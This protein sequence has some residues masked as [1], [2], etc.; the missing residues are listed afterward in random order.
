M[1][2]KIYLQ[3]EQK[4]YITAGIQSITTILNTVLCVILINFGTSI[5]IVKLVSSFVFVLRPV[6]QNL[7]VRK[8]YNINLKNEKE[9]YELK[10][11]WD[12]LA[13][14]IAAVIH[15]NTD[16]TIL[17]IFS[18]TAEVSVY[19]VYLFVVNGVKNLIQSLTGG[20]DASFG[21]MYARKEFDNLN[22]GFKNYEFFYYSIITIIFTST[23]CLI[24]PFVKVYTKEITDVDYIRPLFGYLIVLAEYM[25]AIRLPYNSLVLA[26]G[27]FKETRKG[28][29]FEAISNI[30]IS[31][32]LVKKL[33][34]VGVA[35]GTLF[36]MTVRTIEFMSHSAKYIL[37]R[38]MVYAFIHLAITIIETIIIF[39]LS[40]LI[41][42][43][44]IFTNYFTW[45]KYAIMITIIST[46]ITLIINC[47]IYK[48]QAK[49]TI[50]LIKRNFLRK[51][52]V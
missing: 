7:Y 44:V 11:K 40:N 43:N 32:I 22:K 36:A 49:E 17:T 2:Y 20:I 23:L 9:E 25:W 52:T 30:I 15:G 13:Q 18:N 35:I 50:E 47:I 10:Q 12:G 28:A 51:G 33:G 38:K 1:V 4:T 29:W 46:I 14:H 39:I 48:K 26:V 34:I 41:I 37:R 5:Q 16:I 45:G 31:L 19:T 24:I 42:K 8:K 6:M 21:D 27:H 3:A